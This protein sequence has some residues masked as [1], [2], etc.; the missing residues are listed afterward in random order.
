MNR[1]LK[2]I[3]RDYRIDNPDLN[4][5]LN[6]INTYSE[7]RLS[8]LYQKYLKGAVKNSTSGSG[9]IMVFCFFYFGSL[10]LARSFFFNSKTLVSESSFN[11]H[12]YKTQAINI[13]KSDPNSHVNLFNNR[14]TG[15][16]L[17]LLRPLPDNAEEIFKNGKDGVRKVS[18]KYNKD[19]A[20]FFQRKMEFR[21]D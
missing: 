15:D 2:G 20:H 8:T 12:P 17:F 5:P 11:S 21:K 4:K 14:G 3:L 13:M 18:Y 6:D 16:K 9:M 10:H 1:Q 19:N 7:R